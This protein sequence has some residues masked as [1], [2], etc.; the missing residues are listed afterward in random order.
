MKNRKGVD[1]MKEVKYIVDHRHYKLY[2]VWDGI[3]V[4]FNMRLL[5]IGRHPSYPVYLFTR[6]GHRFDF[7]EKLAWMRAK[8]P[9]KLKRVKFIPLNPSNRH[10]L[11][12]FFVKLV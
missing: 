11:Q 3:R 7:T 12:H 5:A 6:A 8:E 2:Y 10:L 9:E 4:Y 1:M